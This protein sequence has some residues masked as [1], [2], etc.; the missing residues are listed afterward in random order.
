MAGRGS[1]LAG[2]GGIDAAVVGH[3]A[4][5][6]RRHESGTINT[7]ISIASAM[8]SMD[9]K[10]VSRLPLSICDKC[11]GDMPT[12]ADNI[13]SVRRRLLRWRRRKAGIKVSIGEA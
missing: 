5:Q 10:R 1:G 7:V 6:I 11:Y 8:R 13:S 2:A 4:A 3:I 12:L 9:D